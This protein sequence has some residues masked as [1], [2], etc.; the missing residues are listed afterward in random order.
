MY[1]IGST[2][3]SRLEGVNGEYSGAT[4]NKE[5]GLI[6]KLAGGYVPR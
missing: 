1:V 6:G 2:G 4:R 5:V 3:V